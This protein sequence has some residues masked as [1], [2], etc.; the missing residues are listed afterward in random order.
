GYNGKGHVTTGNNTDQQRAASLV[1]FSSRSGART[2]ARNIA[3]KLS[4]KAIQR[5]NAD[6]RALGENADV[7]VILGQDQAP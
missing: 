5:M 6:T 4:I 2:Q 3:D 7:V 1:M